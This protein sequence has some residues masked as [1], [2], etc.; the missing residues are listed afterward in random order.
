M[1]RANHQ[2]ICIDRV[3]SGANTFSSV[4]TAN[5]KKPQTPDF[6]LQHEVWSME[7]KRPKQN[8]GKYKQ[9]YK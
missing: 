5:K 7:I 1:S 4:H 9:K 8:R 3:H 6:F 2:R